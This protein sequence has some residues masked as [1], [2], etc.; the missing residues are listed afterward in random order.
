MLVG[1]VL[2]SLGFKR[3][4]WLLNVTTR[5]ASKAHREKLA[6][7]YVFLLI[8]LALPLTVEQGHGVRWTVPCRPCCDGRY[9]CSWAAYICWILLYVSWS[10]DSPWFQC[11]RVHLP[12]GTTLGDPKRWYR[13]PRGKAVY[14]AGAEWFPQFPN[15]EGWPILLLEDFMTTH[16]GGHDLNREKVLPTKKPSGWPHLPVNKVSG[17]AFRFLVGECAVLNG[18][19]IQRCQWFD[20][21]WF[22]TSGNLF[23]FPKSFGF[24]SSNWKVSRSQMQNL[25][26]VDLQ[27]LNNS[28]NHLNQT[29]AVFD[30][31]EERRMMRNICPHFSMIS[32]QLSKY[33]P[34]EVP[35]PNYP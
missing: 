11:P 30:S 10:S 32:G 24:L 28:I 18:Y 9:F 33:S 17:V 14:K 6:G 35:N 31:E 19:R 15:M 26:W 12:S 23:N 5:I 25:F 4:T 13:R 1:I 34:F 8:R 2:S 20:K 21:L 27:H 16:G 22:D 7:F 3:N 29:N